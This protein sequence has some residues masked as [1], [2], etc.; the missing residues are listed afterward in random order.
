MLYH[1]QNRDTVINNIGRIL[2]ETGVFIASTM[3]RNDLT[4]LHNHLYTFLES[5]NNKFRF[6]E[7]SFSLDNGMEQ[8]NKCFKNVLLKRYDNKL[9]INE[10]DAIINYY[11]SFNGIYDNVVVLAEEYIND[12]RIYLQSIIEKDKTITTTKDEGIF[13]CRK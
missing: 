5:K 3:G 6:R 7:Y 9:V 2:K 12:F 10:T 8:L 1:I 13:I 4:E 11:L